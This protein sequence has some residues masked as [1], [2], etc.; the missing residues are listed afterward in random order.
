MKT[1]YAEV[2]SETLAI[3][4]NSEEEAEAKYC[5][6]YDGEDCPDHGTPVSQCCVDYS[7]SDVYHNM[8]EGE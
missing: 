2:V 6:Y 7:D 3:Q 8:T 4:A 1:Y 5:A